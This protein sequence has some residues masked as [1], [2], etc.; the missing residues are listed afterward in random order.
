M[1]LKLKKFK[2]VFALCSFCF[3]FFLPCGPLAAEKLP[4]PRKTGGPGVLAAIEERASGMKSTFPKGAV[5]DEEL[6]TL[7]WACAGRNRGGKGWTIPTV[8]SKQPYV[9]IYVVSAKGAY[10][11]DGQEHGLSEVAKGDLKKQIVDNNFAEEAPYVFVFVS[12]GE[13]HGFFAKQDPN[14]SIAYVAVGAMTQNLYLAANALG[15]SARY[16]LSFKAD[17]VRS[18]LR[19][20]ED[21]IPLCILPLGKEE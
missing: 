17:E 6:S 21:D 16:M 3:L 14:R 10:L 20:G 11:Y 18:G 12:R 4:E 13:K 1:G 5:S 8:M 9:D 7:L 2:R 19:L 15:I